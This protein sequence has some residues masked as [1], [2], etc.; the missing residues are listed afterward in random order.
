MSQSI[1]VKLGQLLDRTLFA[2]ND[3][4]GV[5]RAQRALNDAMSLT[6]ALRAETDHQIDDASFQ[7]GAAHLLQTL[8][9]RVIERKEGN[10]GL[11]FVQRR[12]YVSNMLHILAAAETPV[13]P[14][15][16]ATKLGAQQS[17][18]TA[19]LKEAE[20]LGLVSQTV[21]AGDGRTRPRV[22]TNVGRGMLTAVKPDWPLRAVRVSVEKP[23]AGG[24]SVMRNPRALTDSKAVMDSLLQ[25]LRLQQS[26]RS[27]TLG[28]RFR[29]VI[30]QKISL[31]GT[32][33]GGYLTNSSRVK[34]CL[35]VIN[36]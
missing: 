30:P 33:P 11:V 32:S 21:G 31:E 9:V 12:K 8:L 23:V 16:L 26:R 17:A 27:K 36:R 35:N 5:S 28:R 18:I 1:S 10:R 19:L 13:S 15:D 34:E 6:G 7:I 20:S 22:L 3:A 29:H 2:I 14:S 25:Q 24:A 4:T